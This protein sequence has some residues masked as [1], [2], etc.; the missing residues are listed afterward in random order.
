MSIAKMTNGYGQFCPVAKASEIFATRWTPLVVRELLFGSH[1][2]NDIHRGVPLMSRALLIERLRQLEERGIVEKR[3]RADALGHEYWLTPAGESARDIVRAL[4]HW[5]LAHTRDRITADDLDPALMMWTMRQRTDLDALP[6][7]R[8][9]IRFE[10]SG[11]PA[12][13]TRFRIMWLVLARS[14]VDVCAKD[15]GFPVDI[16]L[17]GDIAVF[18]AIFLGQT[19]WDEVMAKAVAIEGN[20]QI[21]QQIPEWIQLRKVPRPQPASARSAA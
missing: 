4:G 3:S 21:A 12:N 18:V 13:R 6:D 9:V 5:G 11:V 10:F 17:R 14:G 16:T 1:T 2:F 20:A 15:P 8:V 19:T 7:H